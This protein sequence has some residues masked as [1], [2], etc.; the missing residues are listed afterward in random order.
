MTVLK[1]VRLTENLAIAS[2]AMAIH[3][4][5]LC[6]T[7]ILPQR[8]IFLK[9]IFLTMNLLLLMVM[10]I[11]HSTE[12]LFSKDVPKK[13]CKLP[14]VL[15]DSADSWKLQKSAGDCGKRKTARESTSAQ[16]EATYRQT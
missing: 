16:A 5:A 13:T 11:L 6:V 7:A 12:T 8:R 14:A 4:I 1:R 2:L 10:R 9:G 3:S 15:S